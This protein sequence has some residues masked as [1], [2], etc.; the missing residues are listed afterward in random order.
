MRL[1]RLSPR[2]SWQGV[3]R[4]LAKRAARQL[5]RRR[6]HRITRRRE[7]RRRMAGEVHS[8]LHRGMLPRTM[9]GQTAFGRLVILRVARDG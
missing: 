3:S 5:V 4:L 6:W 9:L 8:A 1:P 2:K 7:T